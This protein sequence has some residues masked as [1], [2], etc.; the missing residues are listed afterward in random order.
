[1]GTLLP[2]TASLLKREEISI[3][4]K[5]EKLL[6][7]YLNEINKIAYIKKMKEKE[8]YFEEREKF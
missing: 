6:L 5:I 2:K 1:M 7:K 3:F 4:L 8:N